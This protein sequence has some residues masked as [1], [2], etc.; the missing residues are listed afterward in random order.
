[1]NM[2]RK[3]LLA[4]ALALAATAAAGPA[5]QLTFDG[6]RYLAAGTEQDD[7]RIAQHFV[8]AT[9]SLSRYSRRVTIADLPKAQSVRQLGL[10]VIRIAKLRSPGFEPEVFSAEGAEDRDLTVTWIALTDDGVAVEFHAARFV[11]LFDAKGKPDGVR[12]H[13]FVAREFTNG[14]HP[15]AV[16][17]S[18]APVIA[19]FADRWVVEL[20]ALDLAPAK[21][22]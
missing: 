20:Q 3:L 9:E 8:R 15:D 1:M 14:R 10:G 17:T 11:A 4:A 7:A 16:L 22:K 12:E 21:A 13:H 5:A 6:E 2:P 18:F 19:G